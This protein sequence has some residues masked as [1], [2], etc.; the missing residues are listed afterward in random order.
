MTIKLNLDFIH[1]SMVFRHVRGEAVSRLE[2]LATDC[3]LNEPNTEVMCLE[4]LPH[5]ARVQ[6]LFSTEE[7]GPGSLLRDCCI[8]RQ[9]FLKLSGSA[10]AWGV[11]SFD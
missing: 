3:A 9:E 4:V 8:S 11:G 5:V 1:I 2:D 6:G 10:M 7:A